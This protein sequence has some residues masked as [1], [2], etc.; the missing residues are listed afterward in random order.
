LRQKVGVETN[1]QLVVLAAASGAIEFDKVLPVGNALAEF[2]LV[3][4][5][6]GGFGAD[7]RDRA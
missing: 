1:Q 5:A 7:V 2:D 3:N 4:P 6:R